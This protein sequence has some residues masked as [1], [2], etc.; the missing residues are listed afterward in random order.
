LKTIHSTRLILTSVLKDTSSFD[1]VKQFA[2]NWN[3]G[4]IHIFAH[5]AG[6]TFTPPGKEFTADG[7]EYQYQVN[8][9]SQFLLTGLLDTE[10]KFADDARILFTSSVGSYA[11]KLPDE[12]NLTQTKFKVS[13]LFNKAILLL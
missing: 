1:S 11:G 2:K 5:N 4:K 12:F 7:F 3:N 13:I 10:D 9:L 6:V 8:F